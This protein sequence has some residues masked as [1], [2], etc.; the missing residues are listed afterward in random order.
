MDPRRDNAGQKPTSGA[1]IPSKR[2][3]FYGWAWY[4]FALVPNLFLISL[5]TFD[6]G[7]M[8]SIIARYSIPYLVVAAI[9]GFR[10]GGRLTPADF[11]FLV[12][13]NTAIVQLL[14]L[15]NPPPRP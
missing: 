4:W 1:P 11:F 14:L 5:P 6:Y 10:R 12:F 7:Y 8:A 9:I 13:G 15:V 3:F 2:C